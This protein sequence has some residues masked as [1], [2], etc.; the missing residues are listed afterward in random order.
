MVKAVANRVT[1]TIGETESARELSF[2]PPSFVC[3]NAA[4]EEIC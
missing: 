4:L 3:I 1:Y 2:P